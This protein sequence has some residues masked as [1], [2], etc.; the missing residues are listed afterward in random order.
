M[1]NP[2]AGCA[3]PDYSVRGLNP[4]RLAAIQ[5]YAGPEVLDVG[6]GSGVY[7]LHLADEFQIRGVDA[8]RFDAWA[9]RPELFGLAD[10]QDLRMPANSV[11]TILSFETLEH[12]PDPRRA[13]EEYSRVCRKN[14]I[15]TVPNCV[16]SPGMRRSGLIFHHWIDRTHVNFWDLDAFA[17]LVS[18]A[19]FTVT[20]RGYINRINLGPL[21]MEAFGLGDSLVA[22]AGAKA[23]RLLQ[24]REYP[25][26]S[27]VVAEK[28]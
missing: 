9:E 19:G 21:M 10:A 28:R 24:R 14:V 13:L 2:A 18:D 8:E 22:R 25:M 23:F 1:T 11:D 4:E 12:L 6:C 26:T 20:Y 17:R 16:V 15:L 5:R 7:V 3:R 27:L